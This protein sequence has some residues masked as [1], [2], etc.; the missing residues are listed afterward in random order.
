MEKNDPESGEH[1]EGRECIF[2]KNRRVCFTDELVPGTHIKLVGDQHY[3]P[4][5]TVLNRLKKA[6]HFRVKM[7]V[8]GVQSLNLA[9][10]S[11]RVDKVAARVTLLEDY[12][13]KKDEKGSTRDGTGPEQRY[14][15]NEDVA[16][17]A[18]SAY[19]DYRAD[20]NWYSDVPPKEDKSVDKEEEKKK[21]QKKEW[22]A[23]LWAKQMAKDEAE[24]QEEI[25][26]AKA[27]KAA[28]EA[29]AKKEQDKFAKDLEEKKASLLEKR[30]KIEQE[31][32]K[33]EQVAKE[34]ME[35]EAEA[36]KQEE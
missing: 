34:K 23:R 2:H 29:E 32:T 18:N 24:K 6:G 36:A 10:D 12:V 11:F 4:G 13:S 25:G 33:R 19:F 30:K 27:E 35:K 1:L 28:A 9:E 26:K 8:G 3:S 21:R 14:D 17:Q 20:E 16:Y 31:V 15:Y 5:A 22:E 7:D